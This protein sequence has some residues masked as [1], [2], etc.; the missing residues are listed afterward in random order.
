MRAKWRRLVAIALIAVLAVGVVRLADRRLT[1]GYY[2]L[3][4]DRT[5]VVGAGVAGH[6]FWARLTGVDESPTT[7][8]VTVS[9]LVPIVSNTHSPTEFVVELRDPL[10]SRTVIDATNGDPVPRTR[11]VSLGAL[12][13]SCLWR[14]ETSS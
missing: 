14:A 8:T 3:V 12:A 5:L 7:V 6:T 13:L 10:G 4:G 2:R 11:C 9:E 1:I